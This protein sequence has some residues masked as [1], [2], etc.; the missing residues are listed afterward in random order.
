MPIS[1]RKK[2]FNRHLG[3]G[4]IKKI[5]IKN[6]L[7]MNNMCKHLTIEKR[8][9]DGTTSAKCAIKTAYQQSKV[10]QDIIVTYNNIMTAYHDKTGKRAIPNQECQFYYES[11][12][13]KRNDPN[14]IKECPGNK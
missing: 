6:K 3:L 12:D 4:Q 13:E 8:P 1:Q 10:S 14:F 9:D 5:I 7:N 2:S 11:Q